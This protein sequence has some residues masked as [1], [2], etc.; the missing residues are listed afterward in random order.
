MGLYGQNS[1]FMFQVKVES[2]NSIANIKQSLKLERYE[3]LKE[4]AAE[5]EINQQADILK[6]WNKDYFLIMRNCKRIL[7]KFG[8]LEEI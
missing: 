3:S 2:D 1:D 7:E 8:E 4:I 6:R 5:L